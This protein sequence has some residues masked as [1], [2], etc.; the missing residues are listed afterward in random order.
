MSQLEQTIVRICRALLREFDGDNS[1]YAQSTVTAVPDELTSE[2]SQ[3]V[4]KVAETIENALEAAKP[5][6]TPP[7]DVKDERLG[8]EVTNMDK[9]V[10]GIV[11]ETKQRGW[12]VI[13][14]TH[15]IVDGEWEKVSKPKPM[16]VRWNN[17]IAQAEVTV[18]EGVEGVPNGTITEVVIKKEKGLNE[19][20]GGKLATPDAPALHNK[21]L[22]TTTDAGSYRMT[23]G[24]H[25][26]KSIHEIYVDLVDGE[27][28]LRYLA[29]KTSGLY[30]EEAKNAAKEYLLSQGLEI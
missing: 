8:A 10:K 12:V 22:V 29:K 13:E 20:H 9:G 24:I 7:A 11:V 6:V 16:S 4:Q 1:E 30:G 2:A 23:T 21:H 28:F 3:E 18:S 5:E 26:G 25:A 14:P 15:T 17:C 19:T 27:V